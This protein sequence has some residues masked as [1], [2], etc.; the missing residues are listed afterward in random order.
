MLSTAYDCDTI[1]NNIWWN[2][3]SMKSLN[4]KIE[5]HD[6]FKITKDFEV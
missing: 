4:V 5:L 3:M 2:T 1:A 6:S